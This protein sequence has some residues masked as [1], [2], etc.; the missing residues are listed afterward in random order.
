MKDVKN[1]VLLLMFGTLWGASEVIGGNFLYKNNIPHASVWLTAWA[2][3]VLGMARGAINKPV[4]STVIGSTA[5]FFKLIN[6]APYFCHLLGI[7]F[8]GLVFDI[9]ATILMRKERK[10]SYRT[11]LTGVLS[12]YSSYALFALLITYIVRY[13][14]WV[15]GGT[16]KV[17]HHIFVGGSFA[18][19]T[20]LGLVPLGYRVGRGA[21]VMAKRQRRW[22]YAGALVILVAL[23]T[24]GRI[25]G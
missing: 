23:W 16:A 25:L 1:W 11:L 10:I 15:A 14:P 13:E 8:L 7:F 20:S 24:L 21:G 6:T 2:F 5:A 18:A 3:F 4:S 19:L 17:I 12:A 22:A 9:A